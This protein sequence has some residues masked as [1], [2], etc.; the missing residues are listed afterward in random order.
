MWWLAGTEEVGCGPGDV[1]E[2][3]VRSVIRGVVADICHGRLMVRRSVVSVVWLRD[4]GLC[5][6]KSKG[7]GGLAINE[8]AMEPRCGRYV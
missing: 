3:A 5:V 7:S 6:A 1:G 4:G 2:V 8:V